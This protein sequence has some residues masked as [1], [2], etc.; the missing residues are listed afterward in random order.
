MTTK[1]IL[2]KN[3]V[4]LIPVSDL[5][6]N[7]DPDQTIGYDLT[8][9]DFYTFSSLDGV[10]LQDTIGVFHPITKE[11]QEEIKKKMMNIEGVSKFNSI[12]FSLSKEICTGLF[13]ITKNIKKSNSPIYVSDE[14][15]ENI[16]DPY[17]QV[18]FR[19]KNTTAGKAI[20]NNCFPEDF[21]FYDGI[22][23]KSIINNMIPKILEKYGKQKTILIFSNLEKAGFKWSTIMSPGIS[24]DD[25]EIPESIIK[26]KQKLDGA[27]TE[28]ADEILKKMLDL[29]KKHL[30]NTGLGDLIESGSTKGWSQPFQLLCAKGL[31]ADPAGNVLPVIKGSF[32]DGLTN[33][34]YFEASS[35][36]RRGI[37]NRTISTSET[38]YLSRQLAFILNSVEIHPQLKDCGT[39]LTLDLRLTKDMI[40]RLNG[41]YILIN[42]KVELFDPK[43]N[44]SGDV[45]YLR[46]P[47]FCKSPKICHVC[48]GKL[49]EKH[50]SPYG[51]IIAAQ[52]IGESSTQSTMRDFH[53]G[54]AIKIFKRDVIEDILNNDPLIELGK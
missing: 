49:L 30:K 16:K 20:F 38:G 5:E 13:I 42:G 14:D 26:L 17:I 18:K 27:S 21:P 12:T 48:Y 43:E 39:K 46:S 15:L 10:F 32:A 45:I 44:K 11:S 41:R 33:K 25:I 24:L 31:I 28:E 23:T 19:N 37:I 36:S 35:G 50:K 22:I 7:Y 8:V 29:L 52:I 3:N 51:G 40:S 53:T 1:D 4:N 9:E 2:K 34:E 54:G 47:I 6:I